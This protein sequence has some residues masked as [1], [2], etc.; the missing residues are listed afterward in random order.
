M[1]VDRPAWLNTAL[2]ELDPARLTVAVLGSHSALEVCRGARAHGLRTL[3]VAQR[4]RHRTYAEH[5]AARG[6]LGCVDETIVVDR[7]RQVTDAPTQ[8]ALRERHCVL[9]PHRSLEVYLQSDYDLI[10][11]GL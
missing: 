2:A 7:F 6:D 11:H 5:Y 3:V 9:V 1:T 8:A 4:G 10:E